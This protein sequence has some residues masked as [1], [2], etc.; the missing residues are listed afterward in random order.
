T[1]RDWAEGEMAKTWGLRSGG[2]WTGRDVFGGP[3]PYSAVA[4]SDRFGPHAKVDSEEF[5]CLTIE[6]VYWWDSPERTVEMRL[7]DPE[8]AGHLLMHVREGRPE[9]GTEQYATFYGKVGKGFVLRAPGRPDLRARAARGYW[10]DS[11][12]GMREFYLRI[13]PDEFPKMTP[14]VPYS[15]VPVEENETSRWVVAEEVKVVRPKAGERPPAPKADVTI[16]G[17]SWS[18]DSG[19]PEEIRKAFSGDRPVLLCRVAEKKDGAE[20]KEF[21]GRA[22]LR[23][24]LEAE[25]HPTLKVGADVGSVTVPSGL[26]WVVIR[27]G[28]ADWEGLAAGVGYRLRPQNARPGSRWA[29]ADGVV[30]PGRK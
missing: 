30:V 3:N 7:D 9:E 6:R 19:I 21:T 24:F 12:A 5:R 2:K 14:G 28:P 26:A 4:L 18:D 27:L 16:A 20:L 17:A 29:V 13:E 11:A 15:L 10:V 22:D 1:F 25:G 23:F 8:T